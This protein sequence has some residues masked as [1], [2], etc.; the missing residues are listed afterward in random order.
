ML[1]FLVVVMPYK[2]KEKQKKSGRNSKHRK[3]EWLN[4]YKSNLVCEL[5]GYHT[6]VAAI[7]FHHKNPEEKVKSIS[8]MMNQNSSKENIMKEIQKCMAVCSNCHAIIHA[9]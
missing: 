3:R 1:I 5:C 8:K 2:D 7:E 6:H 4:E 9:G